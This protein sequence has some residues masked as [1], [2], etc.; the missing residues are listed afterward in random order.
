M[1]KFRTTLVLCCTHSG[2]SYG[3]GNGATVEVP[4]LVH[5]PHTVEIGS[6]PGQLEVMT[7]E[8]DPPEG[9]QTNYCRREFRC[10]EHHERSW[11]S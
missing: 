1:L 3:H 6:V 7:A 11:V 4:G 8:F 10:P 2:C 5:L 9:W